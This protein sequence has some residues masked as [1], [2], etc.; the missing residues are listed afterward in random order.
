M[1]RN[2]ATRTN[3]AAS[4]RPVIEAPSRPG[5]QRGTSSAL[6]WRAE[7]RKWGA[8]EQHVDVSGGG[9]VVHHDW[10]TAAA[11]VAATAVA[12]AAGF[13]VSAWPLLVVAVGWA[14]L[15]AAQI[16]LARRAS[17]DRSGGF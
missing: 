7:T 2:G 11:D 10:L 6:A 8:A 4:T 13:L 9:V 15:S 14:L 16:R 12:A 5:A 1:P 3:Q 17:H